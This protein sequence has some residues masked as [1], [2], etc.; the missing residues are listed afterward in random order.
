MT[1]STPPTPAA[2]PESPLERVLAG[3]ARRVSGPV[4]RLLCVGWLRRRLA[5]RAVKAWAASDRPLIL[6]YGN[7]NRS[8]F[9][10]ELARA[11]TGK[12]PPSAGLFP[13]DGRGSPE[14]TV[15]QARQYGVDLAGHRSR[16]AGRAELAGAEAI[17]VFD[18]ENLARI[19]A[20]APGALRHT[21]LLALLGSDE[22]VAFIEDPH[23]RPRNVLE[24]AFAQIDDSLRPA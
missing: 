23:G 21:H 18:L 4:E 14:A 12:S 24:R 8:P 3:V 15:E 7:I 6:C 13:M 22:A 9:A 5:Q 19:A 1:S 16:V 2:P 10:A 11:R 20:Q 17:F